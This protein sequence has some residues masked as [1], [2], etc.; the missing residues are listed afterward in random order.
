MISLYIL[1]FSR[2]HDKIT[3][4]FF[5]TVSHSF[6]ERGDYNTEHIRLSNLEFS[7]KNDVISI[8]LVHCLII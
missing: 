6:T 2:H 8:L 7:N 3:R 5:N 4:F 1:V